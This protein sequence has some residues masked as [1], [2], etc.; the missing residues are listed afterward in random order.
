MGELD[1]LTRSMRD[2]NK[3]WREGD[4]RSALR[5][6]DRS[7][8]E[9]V[10]QNK[11]QWVQVLCRHAARISEAIN[12]LP[13]VKRYNEEALRYV[14]DNPL[15]LYGLAKVLAEQGE[16]E[17][18]K[19]YATKCVEAVAR[20]GDEIHDAVLDLIAKRWPELTQR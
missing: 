18:A 6:L 8:E 19:V 17:Q 2:S 20:S 11:N 9:A 1:E 15:A 3:L 7:I 14:P 16:S 12:D 5:L 13:L 10:R 4:P